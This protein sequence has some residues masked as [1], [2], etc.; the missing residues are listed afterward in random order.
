MD[1][2]DTNAQGEQD[3]ERR[4]RRQG[5]VVTENPG[6]TS[7]VPGL[8][9]DTWW[10]ISLDLLVIADRN[11]YF[12]AVNPSWER[13]LGHTAAVMT[14]R[15]FLEFVHPDDV[16]ATR[17]QAAQL[18]AG[19]SMAADYTCRFRSVAGDYRWL[20]WVAR[21]TPD[22]SLLYATARDVTALRSAT[23]ALADEQQF[24]LAME[25]SASGM[26]LADPDGTFVEVNTA[27]CDMI[28]SSRDSLIGSTWQSITHPDDLSMDQAILK[29]LLVGTLNSYRL[30]KRYRRA[31]GTTM[32]GDFAVGVVRN[33]DGSVRHLVSQIAD[34]SPRVAA[35]QAAAEHAAL[36]RVV[37]DNST[38]ATI[39]LDRHLRVRYVNQRVVDLSATPASQWVG[40]TYQE[41]GY[42]TSLT[43]DWDVRHHAVLDTGLPVRYEFEIDNADG[44][45][46]YETS[47]V[48]EHGAQGVIT[49]L[50]A[51]S[52]D[53]TDRKLAEVDLVRLATHDT[54]TGLSNRMGMLDEITRSLLS[55][56]R[57]QR[58]TGVLMMDLD[59]FKNVN[60]SLGHAFGD[61][62]LQL[63]AERIALSVRG[64]DLVARPGGD[65]FVVV[66]RD[67]E[68]PSEALHAAWRLVE[69]FRTPFAVMGSELFATASVGVAVSTTDTIA[70]DLI[71]EADTALYVAK[72][73]G[74]DRVSVFNERLRAEAT[75]RLTLEGELRHA[76]SREQLTVW[77]QPEIDLVTGTM[78]ATEAL[79]RWNHPDG[80]LLEAGSFIEVAEDTGLILDIGDWVMLEA[81]TKAAMWN[82][83]RQLR[84]LIV[85]INVSALQLTESGLLDALDDALSRTGADPN[86]LCIEITE[87]AL[88]RRTA[89][90]RSNL[91]GLRERGI[92][93]AADD[94]GTGYA[95]LAYL[96]EYP[97]DVLK[98]DRSFVTDLAS[99]ERSR[100]LVT[101]IVALAD[102]LGI[103]VTAEGVERPEQAAILRQIGCPGAQGFLYSQAVPAEHITLL[104]GHRFVRPG[105]GSS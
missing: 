105:A 92:K 64:G 52:R 86:L 103:T 100:R 44:H 87:T 22:G 104:R 74:R 77:Y 55:G 18:L 29:R 101:G 78:I 23:E 38:E 61:V 39:R 17:A 34:A 96:L 73:E 42:P 53:I 15:P 37:L 33:D 79:V 54:L 3:G 2:T 20:D 19:G 41:M 58:A 27:F 16:E 65:E 8:V 35:E 82:A 89:T 72:A 62:L 66:M 51:T 63:A 99:S 45:R 88:L 98:I 90:A 102:A 84:P 26:C 56:R 40:H 80:T 6:S 5:P 31:D 24:R 47:A 71:R 70:D 68:D 32:W 76:L 25:Y 60:D 13:V 11:G 28:G 1:T 75:D 69:A 7:H 49:H 36:L 59:R 97:V 95:S 4:S 83:D 46:W 81:C 67:L 94:F 48:A 21:A 10:D 93:I 14:S 43:D 91:A 57:S 12:T 50:V 9:A 85:R 30:L